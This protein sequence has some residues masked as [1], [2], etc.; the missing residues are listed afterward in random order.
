MKGWPSNTESP[1][2]YLCLWIF[3]SHLYSSLRSVGHSNI[4]IAMAIG[5]DC[6]VSVWLSIDHCA[7][8]GFAEFP[9]IGHPDFSYFGRSFPACRWIYVVLFPR[10]RN[11]HSQYY[12]N[13]QANC[14]QSQHLNFTKNTVS[15]RADPEI[16]ILLYI[17]CN[18]I[19]FEFPC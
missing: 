2:T 16:P 5:I 6:C 3:P 8:S 14:Q 17:I 19:P 7:Q 18:W 12:R 15:F 4:P 9:E 13:C 10:T 1:D 11:C